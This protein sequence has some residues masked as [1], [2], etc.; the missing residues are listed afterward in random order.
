MNYSIYIYV[1]YVM[2]CYVFVNIYIVI[3]VP[4]RLVL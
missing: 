4:A 2:L 1:M 3:D